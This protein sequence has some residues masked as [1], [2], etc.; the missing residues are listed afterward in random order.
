[1]VLLTIND[2]DISI[3]IS[4]DVREFLVAVMTDLAISKGTFEISFVS[5]EMMIT[6]NKAHL[7]HD[8]VTDIITYNLAEPKQDIDADIYI[9]LEQVDGNAADVGH[10]FEIELK[11]VLIHGLLHLL[12]YDDY[13]DVDRAE[14]DRLQL[15]ILERV[16]AS[17]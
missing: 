14:M 4:F 15:E 11:I 9:C 3:P 13:L 10:S 2:E 6:V 16:T 12:G 5:P 8:Y 17:R 7:G 1:M